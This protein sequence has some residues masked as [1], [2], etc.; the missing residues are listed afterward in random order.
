MADPDTGNTTVLYR[1]SPLTTIQWA[2]ALALNSRKQSI[3]NQW[4]LI[5]IRKQ[6]KTFPRECITINN[7]HILIQLLEHLIIYL[8][9][10]WNKFIFNV[11]ILY[12][13]DYYFPFNN[14][15]YYI[16]RCWYELMMY[17]MNYQHYSDVII[18]DKRYGVSNH[19]C[20][21]CLLNRLFKRRSS[22]AFCEGNPPVTMNS[23]HKG[24]VTRKMFPFDDVIM[25]ESSTNRISPTVYMSQCAC[26]LAV[27][28]CDW[29]TMF[30]P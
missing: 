30:Q 8:H 14:I 16:T 20:L 4:H 18:N 3:R 6:S 17:L 1:D 7:T 10:N 28:S 25:I 11:S 19:R 15:E 24:L 12:L 9:L 23:R 2:L 27:I 21:D 26:A 29:L 13:R 5:V 22:I